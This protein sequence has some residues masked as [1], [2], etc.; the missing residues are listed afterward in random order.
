MK[1]DL[2]DSYIRLRNIDLTKTHSE[3]IVYDDRVIAEPI[4]F[5]YTDR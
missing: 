1:V 5:Q 3:E 2:F 4:D